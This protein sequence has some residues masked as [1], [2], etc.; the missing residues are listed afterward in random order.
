MQSWYQDYNEKIVYLKDNYKLS[1]TEWND[2]FLKVT[3]LIIRQD[4]S[5]M[6]DGDSDACMEYFL[7]RLASV[8]AT[9]AGAHFACAFLDISVIGGILCHSAAFIYQIS[10]SNTARMELKNCRASSYR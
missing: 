9:A 8:S 10:E 5:L 6:S 3:T 4:W 1:D 2:A 7:N